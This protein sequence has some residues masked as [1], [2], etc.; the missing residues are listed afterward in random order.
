VVSELWG[1]PPLVLHTFPGRAISTR[2]IRVR[3]KIMGLMK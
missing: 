1:V 2:I 3:V